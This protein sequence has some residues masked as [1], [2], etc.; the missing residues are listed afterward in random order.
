MTETPKAKERRLRFAK[1]MKDN[2]MYRMGIWI[3]K[4]KE[5]Q[6]QISELAE[7]L[8]KEHMETPA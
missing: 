3:P 5:A 1:S 7:R 6:E 8:R 4:T 2:G